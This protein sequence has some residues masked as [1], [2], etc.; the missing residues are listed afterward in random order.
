MTDEEQGYTPVE[1]KIA[2]I[3]NNTTA[4]IN[5]GTKDDVRVGD[6]F[7]VL[8]DEVEEV[9][10]PDSGDIIGELPLE[11]IRLKVTSVDERMSTLE[12]YRT[13]VTGGLTDSTFDIF[14][15]RRETQERMKFERSERPSVDKTVR[16]GDRVVEIL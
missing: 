10:D 13:V 2:H 1:G 14:G 15:P 16:I 6:V 5:R 8:S 7:A 9:K 11:K 3:V 4:I 12:T